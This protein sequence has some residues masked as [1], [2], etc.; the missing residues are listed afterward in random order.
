M[1]V[2]VHLYWNSGIVGSAH[3]LS[4]VFVNSSLGEH[5][6][7]N[8]IADL[9]QSKMVLQQGIKLKWIRQRI[10]RYVMLISVEVG[11]TSVF[12]LV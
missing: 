6:V 2:I 4:P 11:L 7:R 12:I 1:S 9:V 8:S 10:E 5:V 3:T